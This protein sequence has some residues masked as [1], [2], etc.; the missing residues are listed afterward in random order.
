MR[1][2]MRM[3]GMLGFAG[4]EMAWYWDGGLRGD[5]VRTE[6]IDRWYLNEDI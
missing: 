6:K 3:G 4:G 5:G 2:R 1:R